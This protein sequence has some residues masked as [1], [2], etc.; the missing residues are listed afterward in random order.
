LRI[1]LSHALLIKERKKAV[2]SEEA[3]RPSSDPP[4]P[5]SPKSS[6]PS[7]MFARTTYM[8]V[9]RALRGGRGKEEPLSAIVV[10]QAAPG[11]DGLPPP[12]PP[13]SAHLRCLMF[14]DSNP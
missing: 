10:L 3:D 9:S 8:C 2:E 11:D 5:F 1:Q 4:L 7:G 12:D 14:D 6:P 13:R